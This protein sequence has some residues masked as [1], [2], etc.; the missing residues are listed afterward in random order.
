MIVC[1]TND[2]LLCQFCLF[3]FQFAV[4]S[5]VVYFSQVPDSENRHSTQSVAVDV[6]QVSVA[7]ILFIDNP[8]GT[9][10]SYVTQDS[11]FTT[12]VHQIAQD[13]MTTLTAFL[14][15]IPEFQVEPSLAHSGAPQFYLRDSPNA[16][17]LMTLVT[18]RP[19]IL[20][21]CNSYN[22]YNVYHVS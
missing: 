22:F 2:S 7:S 20:W 17:S 1:A 4:W 13:L 21:C 3:N 14:Q 12:D 11:A 9:G 19:L 5:Y 8:V 6:C 18:V 15:Q 10:Y 16:S